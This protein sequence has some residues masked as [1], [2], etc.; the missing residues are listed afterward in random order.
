MLH[1]PY[2]V[3][4]QHS[5]IFFKLYSCRN[6]QF[7]PFLQSPR[8][9]CLQTIDFSGRPCLNEH[10]F[11][12]WHC[13]FRKNR[14]MPMSCFDLELCKL[15]PSCSLT[16]VSKSKA[17]P[18]SSVS[19]AIVLFL[20]RACLESS[21]SRQKALFRLILAAL[22]TSGASRHYERCVCPPH[23]ASQHSTKRAATGR[24]T[25]R[26]AG[27]YQHCTACTKDGSP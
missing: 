13:P 14:H 15:I 24:P 17:T 10:W 20:V 21:A 1:S 19:G 25:R 22:R 4:N 6:S 7:S 3:K 2:F 18:G 16:N 27:P 12:L 9:Q 26:R 11:P 23:Q 5:G 8:S